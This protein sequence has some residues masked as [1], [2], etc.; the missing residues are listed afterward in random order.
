MESR[1]LGGKESL[2]DIGR[3]HDPE[4]EVTTN[5]GGVILTEGLLPS[6]WG[7]L[8]IIRQLTNEPSEKYNFTQYYR[9]CFE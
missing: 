7:F 6:I 1:I 2:E 8:Q 9:H 5:G 3:G 4:V